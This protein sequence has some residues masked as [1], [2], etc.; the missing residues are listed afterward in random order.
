MADT[1]TTNLNLTKPEVGASTDTWGTKLNTDLDTLDAIFASNGTSIALNLDGAV[2]DSS[3]IGGATPAAGTFT[4]LTAN[5]SITG[6]LATAAQTNIT[7]VGSL[8]ALDVTGTATMDGLTVD[9][10][11][12]TLK[13]GSS[14]SALIIKDAGDSQAT[15]QFGSTNNYKMQGGSDYVGFN[16][17]ANGSQVL[18]VSTGGD[19]SFYNTAGN[20]QAL[21]WDASAESLGIGTTSPAAPLDILSNSGANAINLRARSANDYS[22]INF[23][24]NDGTETVGGIANLRAGVSS[25]SLL[26]YAGTTEKMRIDSS[27]NLGIGMSPT[28]SGNYT[29]LDIKG[30]A[31][32]SSALLRFYDG[33]GTNT[34]TIQ[35]D[36]N[37]GVLLA[38]VG[39]RPLSFFTNGSEKMTIDSSGNVDIKS[40][41][42]LVGTDSGDAFN[43]HSKIRI[44]NNDHAYL[45]IKSHTAKTAGIL[46]GDTDDDF[47]G[48]I[49]YDN[50]SNYLAFNSNDAEK[51]RI[52]SSGNLLVGTTSSTLYS[53]SSETGTNITAQGGL[54]VAHNGTNLPVFNRITSDGDIVDFRKNGTTVGSIFVSG[55]DMGLGTGNVGIR[56]LDIGQDR[57]VPRETDNTSA[58]AAIDLG[59]SSSR[60]RNIYLSGG[61]R[62][63]GTG[64]ANELNDYEEGTWTPTIYATTTGTN[65]ITS[66][67]ANNY[68]KIGRLVR[69]HVYISDLNGTALRGDSGDIRLAGL[70]FAP[71][72]YG[73]MRLLYSN[74]SIGITG[75]ATGNVV[76]FRRN[77]SQTGILPTDINTGSGNFMIEITYETT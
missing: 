70:P 71:N 69:V 40:G 14:A 56:F 54:Y 28:A 9:G 75:Y 12:S 21:F 36:T 35:S 15:L 25:G 30:K 2:I 22:F 23:K 26:F 68:T 77:E 20:S 67:T 52:D 37:Y 6:T 46:L 38:A 7:S 42:L 17:L 39:A 74:Q 50:V 24:S 10:A 59:D 1:F 47:V 61:V 58:D 13:S 31:T 27:G 43:A 5:T 76:H 49:V 64:A 41:N 53:S 29:I 4:T 63:G 45:Q 55:D 8:T 16:L 72:A 19:I 32:A 57:I 18:K 48:G 3:V 66:Y 11:T 60:F 51:M 62:L 65:R 44:Q 33:A 34:G 73:H